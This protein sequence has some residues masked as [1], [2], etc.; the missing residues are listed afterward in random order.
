MLSCR[1]T[2][3]FFVTANN[4]PAADLLLAR[5][6]PAD[7][8]A[9][10]APGAARGQSLVRLGPRDARALRAAAPGAVGCGGPQPEGDAEAPGRGAAHGGGG[11]PGVPEQLQPRAFR[12]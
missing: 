2:R 11:R 12:L 7:S 6:Q 1:S 8:A 9:P 10:A 5:S 4:G 3:S